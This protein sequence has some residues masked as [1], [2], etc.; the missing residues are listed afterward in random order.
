MQILHKKTRAILFEGKADSTKDLLVRAH[1]D[2][3]ILD[4]ADLHGVYL[5]KM[6][7]PGIRLRHADLGHSRIGQCDF[8]DSDFT[9]ADFFQARILNS[10]FAD[11]QMS[12]T[13]LSHAS[14]ALSDFRSVDFLG[15]NFQRTIF[16]SGD[17]T[18]ARFPEGAPKVENLDSKILAAIEAGGTLDMG[19]WHTSDTTHCRAGWAVKLAGGP[20]KLIEGWFG[21]CA[22]GT[23]IYH[24]STGRVPNFF[25]ND[26]DTLA[27]IRRCA[28]LEKAKGEL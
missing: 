13:N 14:L 17:F 24:A 6:T 3:V 11:S 19:V 8:S 2:N 4:G 25:A 16:D 10:T 28:D 18:G 27:D 5:Y 15:A 23:L 20:G 7:A 22:A 9:G 1:S 21:P 26:T 12:H